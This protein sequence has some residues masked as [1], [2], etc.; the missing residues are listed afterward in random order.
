MVHGFQGNSCDMRLLKNNIALLHPEAMFLCSSANEDYTE[1]DIQEM[2]VRLAQE[3]NSYITQ[4]CPGSSLG[5]ISFIA[6]SLGGLIVRSAL[7]YLEEHNDKMYNYFSLSS[8]Q[9]GYMYN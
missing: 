1:G 4:Y 8:P 3:V 9:L 5:K 7:P 6:H 2:G